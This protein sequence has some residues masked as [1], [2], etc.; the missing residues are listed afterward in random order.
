MSDWIHVV[1]GVLRD[2]QGNI[3]LAQRPLD[4]HLGGLWEF[5]GGKCEANELAKDALS[6][7]L[8]EEL[9]LAEIDSRPLI[10]VRHDYGDKKIFLDVYW[11]LIA[12]TA[13]DLDEQLLPDQL[14]LSLLWLGLVFQMNTGHLE[15]NDAILGV[16]FGYGTL[17]FIYHLFKMLTGKEG[18]GYGDFK[19]LSALGAWLGWQMIPLVLVFSSV[20]GVIFGI[21][22]IVIAKRDRQ[23]PISFGP[24]LAAGGFIGMFW[25]DM[26]L[27]SYLTLIGLR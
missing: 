16:I 11:V 21:A 1:A 14:T 4:K 9:G 2:V 23:A 15:L 13:I 12:L 3:L 8:H 10:Q 27:S 25:G 26:L 20:T 19:L 5:P 6:R 17:W 7:E 24:F 18:M 22:L